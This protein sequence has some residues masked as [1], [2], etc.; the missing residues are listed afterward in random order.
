MYIRKNFG[1]DDGVGVGVGSAGGEGVGKCK[2][3]VWRGE[4]GE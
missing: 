2:S 4:V 1:K 3:R